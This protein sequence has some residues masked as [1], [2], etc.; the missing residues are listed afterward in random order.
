MPYIND[1]EKYSLLLSVMK[2][3]KIDHSG[4]LNYLITKLICRYMKIHGEKYQFYN[5]CVGVLENVKIELARRK[6]GPY[7]TLKC[8]E[9]GDVY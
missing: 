6:I 8:Q 9:N 1:R 7:E 2:D 5:D 4:D 3:I